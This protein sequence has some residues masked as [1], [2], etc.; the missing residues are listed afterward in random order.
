MIIYFVIPTRFDSQVK[1]IS[2]VYGK[3]LRN[4][5]YRNKIA[6]QLGYQN[7]LSAG[8]TVNALKN[9]IINSNKINEKSKMYMKIA[10][11]EKV[12]DPAPKI[13]NTTVI[14]NVTQENLNVKL[15]KQEGR[16]AK[17][18]KKKSDEQNPEENTTVN[19]RSHVYF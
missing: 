14:E 12:K 9:L 15:P 8:G 16:K 5:S 4:A 10:H 6:R 1:N 11:N 13:V 7:T 3:N 2:A 18:T 19:T 17:F